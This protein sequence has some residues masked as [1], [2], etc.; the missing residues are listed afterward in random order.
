MSPVHLI[1][2]AVTLQRLVELIHSRRNAARLIAAGGIEA[3][4][5]HYPA[6]VALHA[7]W[8]GT[9]WL[10]VPGDV[11]IVWPFLGLFV[12]LQFGRV[13]VLWHLGRFWTTRIITLPGAPLVAG[14]PY[15]FC[16][17]PNYLV[18][19]GEIASLPLAFGAWQVAVI[20]TL[21][22]AAVLAWRIRVENAALATRRPFGAQ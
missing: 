18:V 8:L 9:L 4:R 20:F 19:A 7:A 14:G 13:W 16:R 11:A 6:L 10:L 5:Q 12:L 22:N 21:A 17:H 2:A 3:G 1:L 15:R